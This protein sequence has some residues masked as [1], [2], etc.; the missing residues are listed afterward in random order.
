MKRIC[1][2]VIIFIVFLG[3][4]TRSTSD[5]DSYKRG[6]I[7]FEELPDTVKSFL[8][9]KPSI[10]FM[11]HGSPYERAVITILDEDFGYD[12]QPVSFI[13][14]SWIHHLELVDY[15]TGEKYSF[16]KNTYNEPFIVHRGHLYV[17]V[18][19]IMR[20][21]VSPKDSKYIEFVLE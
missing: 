8:N 7:S 15:R 12:I 9:L 10:I 17:P 20:S 4:Y 13:F 19:E 21:S 11:G 2:I 6:I 18:K 5:L 16:N 1:Y 3:F 14:P